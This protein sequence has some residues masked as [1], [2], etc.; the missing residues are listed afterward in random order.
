MALVSK[1]ITVAFIAVLWSPVSLSDAGM[2]FL[3]D[4]AGKPG[5]VTTKSGLQYRVIEEGTGLK[6]GAA[7]LVQVHYHGTL[8]D[9]KVFDSSV[10]RGQPARFALNQVIKGWTEG[11]QTMREGGKTAFYIPPDIAYG[12]NATGAIPANATLIFEVELLNVYPLNIP[13]TLEEVKAY[14]ISGM[15]CGKPPVLPEDKAGLSGIKTQADG[16][17]GCVRDY[18]QL[19]TAELQGLLGL[20]D[21][22]GAMR[23]AV[24]DSFSRSREELGAELAVA[25]PFLQGYQQLRDASGQ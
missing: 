23:E 13:Q 7:D 19:V 16:Y 15:D 20:A 12:N 24:L 21:G 6:P 5:V 4:N 22:E 2:E 1:F 18:Y 3:R 17:E 10:E 14:R 25:L 11:L 8:I 9:G